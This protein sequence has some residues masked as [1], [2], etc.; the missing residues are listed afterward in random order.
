LYQSGDA[1]LS[2]WTKLTSAANIPDR[3]SVAALVCHGYRQFCVLCFWCHFRYWQDETV[4]TN[5]LIRHEKVCFAWE[6][7]RQLFVQLEITQCVV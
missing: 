1:A 2:E 4:S 6:D 3:L 7:T 5:L